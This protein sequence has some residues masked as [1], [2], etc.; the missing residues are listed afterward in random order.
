MRW[1]LAGGV[2]L[3][4]LAVLSG[5]ASASPVAAP[6]RAQLQLMP[7]PKAV[8]GSEGA[9]LEVDSS[10]GWST[11]KE[12]A[13]DD[14]DPTMTAAKLARIGRITGF[15]VEFDDLSK[16]SLPGLLVDADSDV[17]LFSSEAG[18]ARYYALQLSEFR[19]FE[20]KKLQHGLSFD[21]VS[22]FPV[23]GIA[24]AKGIR[25]RIHAGALTLW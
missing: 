16:A 10:S 21:H 3:G 8:Y 1:A 23:P 12:S 20:G 17:E 18:A 15:D 4:V 5:A 19:R 13:G 2:L 14:F 24:V 22:Y 7:L 25:F 9:P 6:T 11:N